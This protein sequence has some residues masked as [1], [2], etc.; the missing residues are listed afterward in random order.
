MKSR[1]FQHMSTYRIPKQSDREIAQALVKTASAMSDIRGF[2][3]MTHLAH[4]GGVAVDPANLDG[5][6]VQK[7]ILEL[8]GRAIPSFQLVD[9]IGGSTALQLHRKP[10]LVYDEVTLPTDWMSSIPGN[11]RPTI[12]PIIYARLSI[13]VQKNLRC[14][15]MHASMSGAE[16]TAWN[17]FRTAQVEVLNSLQQTNQH[18]LVDSAK[19]LELMRNAELQKNEELRQR[20]QKD[21]DHKQATLAEDHNRKQ[22][23]LETRESALTTKLEDFET[24]E[25]KYVARQEAKKQL[26]Q[27]K[28]WL[29]DSSLTDQTV[30]KSD[31]SSLATLSRFLPP[32]RSLA[33]S[34][35]RTS[36]YSKA[37][38]RTC[39]RSPGGNGWD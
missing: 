34:P 25:S 30:K 7:T 20:L 31:Q 6:G 14:D 39:R 12:G 36:K 11:D 5:S 28:A 15:D 8:N 33:G 1:T 4:G 19:Q 3:V 23:S 22:L 10:E 37:R 29:E 26:E 9:E 2:R 27:L 18:L 21:F 13:E 32:E 38:A 24:K 35:T 16:D 17:R